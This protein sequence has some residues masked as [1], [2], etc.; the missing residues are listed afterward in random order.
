MMTM[1]ML[2]LMIIMS[3][4]MI[5]IMVKEM[6][7]MKMRMMVTDKFADREVSLLHWSTHYRPTLSQSVASTCARLGNA[8]E[9]L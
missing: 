6:M 9:Y 4:V 3:K 1:R 8:H 2:L 5:T 7:E